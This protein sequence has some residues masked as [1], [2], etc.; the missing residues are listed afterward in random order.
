VTDLPLTMLACRVNEFGPPSA[1]SFEQ[2]P[3]PS[4]GAGEVLVRVHAAGVGPK[5]VAAAFAADT[6][7]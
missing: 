2:I 5:C 3:V 6:R 1:I 4:P 7:L